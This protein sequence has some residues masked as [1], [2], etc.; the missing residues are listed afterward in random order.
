MCWAENGFRKNSVTPA[1][2]AAT[3]SAADGADAIMMI[4]TWRLGCSVD[5][6]KLRIR[7]KCKH[8]VSAAV[9]LELGSA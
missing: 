7:P 1:S 2:R 3:M 4:G 8:P 5:F 9:A 6:L